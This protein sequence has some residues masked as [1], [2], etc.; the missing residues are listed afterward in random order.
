[1]EKIVWSKLKVVQLRKEL[2]ARKVSASG[3]KADLVKK[4]EDHVKETGLTQPQATEEDAKDLMQT[5]N[6]PETDSDATNT[7]KATPNKKTRGST[8]K[9]TPGTA[10][11]SNRRKTAAN[12][13]SMEI[14]A[15]DS[16][17]DSTVSNVEI[18]DDEKPEKIKEKKK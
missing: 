12:V 15:D 4:I 2:L 9:K 5:S 13:E 1:M 17:Q 18:K 14:E 3:L 8:A 10:R 6:D 16:T 11:K 7:P